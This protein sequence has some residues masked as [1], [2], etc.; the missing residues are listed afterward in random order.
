MAVAEK[1]VLVME[2]VCVFT[3]ME[4][5]GFR[6]CGKTA[7][8]ESHTH[9]HTRASAQVHEAGKVRIRLMNRIKAN[10]LVVT[11]IIIMQNAAPDGNYLCVTSYIYI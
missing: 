11:L 10:F 7:W 3:V 8:H 6:T 4:V 1:G 9:T 2:P 5:S